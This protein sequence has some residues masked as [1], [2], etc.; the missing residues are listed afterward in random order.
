MDISISPRKEI[1]YTP[2]RINQENLYGVGSMYA[3]ISLYSR[4]KCVIHPSINKVLLG[5]IAHSAQRQ[6]KLASLLSISDTLLKNPS[7]S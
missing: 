1:P 4:P 5:V 6:N 3:H 2:F 7:F